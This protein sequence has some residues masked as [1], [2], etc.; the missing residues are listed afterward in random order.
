MARPVCWHSTVHSMTPSPVTA[1]KPFILLAAEI[2]YIMQLALGR[3][4]H[5]ST[6]YPHDSVTTKLRYAE[7]LKH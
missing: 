7:R 1:A 6:I 2:D 3:L 5:D 4:A